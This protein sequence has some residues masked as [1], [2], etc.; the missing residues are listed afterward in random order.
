MPDPAPYSRRWWTPAVL[1]ALL[2]AALLGVM[3]WQVIARG[4]FIAWDWPVHEY[5]DPRV[6]DRP[7]LTSIDWVSNV[8][9]QRHYTV[10]I[11]VGGGAWVAYRQHRLRPLVAIVA[12]LAT[13][14]FVGYGIKLGLARTPPADGIDILHGDGQAFPSGHTANAAFTWVFLVVVLFGSRG[15]RPDR[16]RFRRWLPVALAWVLVASAL[17]V[18]LDYHWLSDI[19]GGWALGAPAASVA[20]LVLHAPL[21]GGQPSPPGGEPGE[22]GR[23]G[24]VSD[25]R[26]GVDA[27]ARRLGRGASA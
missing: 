19:P 8:G 12:G 26:H 9:G 27:A 14:F 17:M 7:A 3:T 10:P 20:V 13:I 23:H 18:L 24:N 21:R 2:T 22:N 5:V 1:S 6:P 15:L 4:P 11:L 25:R 16:T